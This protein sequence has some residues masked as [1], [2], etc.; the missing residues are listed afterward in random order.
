[1]EIYCRDGSSA[2]LI[3]DNGP[4]MTRQSVEIPP[5]SVSLGE[6]EGLYVGGMPNS[7]L[8]SFTRYKHGIK[9]CVADLVLNTDYRLQVINHSEVGHNVGEC[10]V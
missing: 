3:V 6:N 4:A 9:G 1:V 2:V 5:M 10:E 7:S 8:Q